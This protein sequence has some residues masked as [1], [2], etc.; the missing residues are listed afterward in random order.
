MAG[1]VEWAIQYIRGAFFA[2]CKFAD[3]DELNRQ[4]EIRCLGEATPCLDYAASAG[5]FNI[6]TKLRIT[7]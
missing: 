1:R 5:P 3:L 2:G 7:S 4:A 6:V